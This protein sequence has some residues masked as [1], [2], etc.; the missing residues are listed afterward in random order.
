MSVFNNEST[1]GRPVAGGGGGPSISSNSRLAPAELELRPVSS[2]LTT[3][4]VGS[5]REL[6]PKRERDWREAF[7]PPAD[8]DLIESASTSCSAS[9]CQGRAADTPSRCCLSCLLS[10]RTAPSGHLSLCFV[11]PVRLFPSDSSSCPRFPHRSRP[12]S[13]P[14]ALSPR[15]RARSRDP[16]PRPDLHLGL[17]ALL[18]EQ[19]PWL[20][21]AARISFE[22]GHCDRAEDDGACHPQL[23]RAHRPGRRGRACPS[24][25]LPA[26][27]TGIADEMNRPLSL[28]TVPVLHAQRS[29]WHARHPACPLAD[30]GA[31]GL[32]RLCRPQVGRG[33]DRAAS[34]GRLRLLDP[35][36]VVL[37]RR[38]ARARARR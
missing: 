31:R 13:A 12:A 8:E 17:P 37:D 15:L 7:S 16:H 35:V 38:P 30:A 18:Q 2:S 26:R 19:H 36:E 23:A 22:L 21:D 9:R 20:Q 10:S 34:A 5:I 1:A 27:L 4:S 3:I 33:G 25:L 28:L 11:R 32:C 14:S 29:R 24:I 6:K